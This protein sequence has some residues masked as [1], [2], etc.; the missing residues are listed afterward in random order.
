MGKDSK[1]KKASKE[2][3]GRIAP[4]LTRQV[5][6]IAHIEHSVNQIN[7]KLDQLT[8]SVNSHDTRLDD[9]KELADKVEPYQPIYGVSGVITDPRRDSADRCRAIMETFEGNVTKYNILDIGSSLGYVSFFLADRGADV[10]GWEVSPS[11][12]AVAL[13]AQ[14]INGIPVSFLNKALDLETAKAIPKDKFDIAII[15]SVFHHIIYDEGIET[16]RK[17]VREL[18]N[19]IPVLIVELARKGEDSDLWWDA[20]QPEN[21]LDIFKGLDVNIETIGEAGTHLSQSPR[22]LYKIT[23]KNIRVNRKI[24]PIKKISKMAYAKSPVPFSGLRREYITS[25]TTFIKHY[26]FHE[27]TYDNTDQIIN[28]INVLNSLRRL[29]EKHPLVIDM[30]DFEVNS[31]GASI[32]F[33]KIEG[34]LAEEAPELVKVLGYSRILQDLVD[35]LAFLES[36][37]YHHNDIR[38]WNVMVTRRHAILIDYGLVS[39]KPISENATD[40]LWTLHAII[41]GKREPYDRHKRSALPPKAEMGRTQDI[42][43][44]YDLV[45]GGE[46]SF[47]TIKKALAKPKSKR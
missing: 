25:S 11:N 32:V 46:T 27:D 5:Q 9:L 37:G 30:E 12:M 1:V 34:K 3:I 2:A 10:E 4:P 41:T 7:N 39:T 19:K 26:Y 40:L 16:T 18:V 17:I 8:A 44:F 15:L 28:E 13:A 29:G 42:R 35:V 47:G 36:A 20:A 24:Y 23:G 21:E 6:R 31:E 14:A 33:R 22:N 43:R 45:A 38:S